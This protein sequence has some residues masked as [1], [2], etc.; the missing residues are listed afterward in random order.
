MTEKSSRIAVV[1]AVVLAMAAGFGLLT[2]RAQ[3]AVHDAGDYDD[4]AL[5]Y[6]M[7]NGIYESSE[8]LCR[9]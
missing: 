7:D 1:C 6:V 4:Y 2:N 8:M 9:I 5:S 3:G